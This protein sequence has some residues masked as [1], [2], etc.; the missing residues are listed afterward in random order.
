MRTIIAATAFLL[1]ACG[2]ETAE[3]PKQAA[4]PA[5]L[6]PGEY[7]V[8]SRV[9]QL[10]STD[11]SPLPTFAKQGES[12]TARGCVGADGL[13]APE[14]LAARGD[15]CQLQNPYVRSGRLSFQLNCTRS[16]Q[17]QVNADVSGTYTAEGFTGTVTTASLF[18]GAGDYQLVEEITARK[19]SDTCTAAPD[20]AA[21][22]G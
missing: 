7:E 17:G 22:K 19:V 12:R 21:T 16:G 11:N 6:P 3:A 14:L 20:G 8:T 1:S 5:T 9:T 4:A 10:R 13:P 15:R 2:S 18:A